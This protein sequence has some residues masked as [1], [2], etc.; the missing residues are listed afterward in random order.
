MNRL[1]IELIVLAV[2]SGGG[3]LAW[4]HHDHVEQEDGIKKQV[5]VEQAAIAKQ[6]A[7]DNKIMQAAEDQHAQEIQQIQAATLEP[8]PVARVLCYSTAASSVPKTSVHD[9]PSPAPVVVHEDAPVYPDIA[10]ALKLLA[11]RADQLSADARELND[12]VHGP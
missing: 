8:I 12:E 3:F 9:D 4:L 1:V 11:A 2:L 7:I 6:Q 10:P 5:A